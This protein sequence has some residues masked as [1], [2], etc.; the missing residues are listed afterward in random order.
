MGKKEIE[1]SALPLD[2]AA[3]QE[4]QVSI[5]VL[6]LG[7]KQVTQALYRQ[8]V[9]DDLID[10][11]TGTLNGT[12]WGW[13]NLHIDCHVEILHL[14]AIWEENG[15]LKRSTVFARYQ[16]SEYH[17]MVASELKYLARAYVGMV[18]L[19]NK[20]F[21]IK[22]GNI[23][24]TVKDRTLKIQLS[25]NMQALVGAPDQ[26]KRYREKLVQIQA[27]QNY[28]STSVKATLI[29]EVEGHI[30][31]WP[32]SVEWN[33]EVIARDVSTNLSIG[34]ESSKQYIPF[35]ENYAKL[36]DVME[37]IATKLNMIER[38]WIESYQTIEKQGQLFIAVSGVWK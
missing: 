38:N 1:Q 5:K 4:R 23:F 19:A 9:E 35:H 18:F 26:L 29:K 32:K 34:G 22:D 27:E 21:G 2:E 6:T 28:P 24:I 20:K 11:S 3:V 37:Q 25:E 8:L 15:Q 36:Y 7:T 10:E 30:E 14:H 12:V 33:K 17:K 16:Q 13:V 31:Y